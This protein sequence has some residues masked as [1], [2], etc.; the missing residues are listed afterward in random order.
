[1]SKSRY[2][3]EANEEAKSVC[4]VVS[5]EGRV[6]PVVERLA[7]RDLLAQDVLPEVVTRAG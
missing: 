4:S 3:Q 6:F 1:M 2:E 7:T 5:L